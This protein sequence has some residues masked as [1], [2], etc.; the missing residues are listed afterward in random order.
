MA[1]KLQDIAGFKNVCWGKTKQ[2]AVLK[3][4]IASFCLH[5][6]KMFAQ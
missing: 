4:E 2:E 1:A 6:V 3:I 5:T